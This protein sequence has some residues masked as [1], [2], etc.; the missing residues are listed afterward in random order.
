MG[1]AVGA[2]SLHRSI[3]AASVTFLHLPVVVP[4]ACAEAASRAARYRR[5]PTFRTSELQNFRTSPPLSAPQKIPYN[6]RNCKNVTTL[7][8][9]EVWGGSGQ[10]YHICAGGTVKITGGTLTATGGEEAAGIGGGNN[11]AGGTLT[12]SG[13]TVTASGSGGAGIGGGKGGAGGTV[14]ISGGTVTAI[15]GE[16]GHGLLAG[17]ACCGVAADVPGKLV[18]TAGFYQRLVNLLRTSVGGEGGEGTREC[19]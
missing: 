2:F 5:Q 8:A 9:S 13:G 10:Q 18:A 15:G 7:S 16:L 4:R 6:T 12:V 1:R 11:S 19:C 14:A 17:V 3:A